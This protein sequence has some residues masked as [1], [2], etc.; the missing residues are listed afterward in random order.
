MCIVFERMSVE[1]KAT[2]LW[3]LKKERARERKTHNGL[4][5]KRNLRKRKEAS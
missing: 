5:A 2:S 3:S 4:L 1:D